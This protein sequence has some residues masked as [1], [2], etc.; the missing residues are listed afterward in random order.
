MNLRVSRNMLSARCLS[1][2]NRER[3]TPPTIAATIPCALAFACRPETPVICCATSEVN[4][5]IPLRTT[6]AVP[7]SVLRSSVP[8]AERGQDFSTW[9]RKWAP[10]YGEKEYSFPEIANEIGKV[11]GK[12]VGYEQVD[13]WTLKRLAASSPRPLHTDTLWQH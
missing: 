5:S 4:L 6:A 8:M 9:S 7:E 2:A 12:P 10:L 1:C 3:T 11:I 13:A